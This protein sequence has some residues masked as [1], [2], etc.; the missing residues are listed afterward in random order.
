MSKPIN[1]KIKNISKS[2]FDRQSHRQKPYTLLLGAGASIS[3]GCP[4][5]WQ[6]CKQYCEEH[7]VTVVDDDYIYAFQKKLGKQ[8]RN[9]IDSYMA[10]AK[11]ISN[12]EPSMG[13]YHLATLIEKGAFETIITTNFDNL[14]EKTLAKIMPIDDIKVLIRGEVT[15]D[16][17]ADFIDKGIPK[18]K[19]I[20]LHGDLQSNIFFYQDKQTCHIS[21]RLQ[22]IL[23]S[24]IENGSIIIGSEMEDID[25][26][27]IYNGNL[28]CNYFVNPKDP[29]KQT[30]KVLNLDGNE[31][32]II[33]NITNKQT[34][35]G[36]EVETI[37][38][39]GEFDTFFTELNLEYQRNVIKQKASERKDI[40]KTILDRQEKDAGYIN[41]SRLGTMIEGFWNNVKEEYS[42]KLPDVIVFT[43]DPTAPGGMDLKRRMTDMIYESD[44]NILIET[45]KIE[46]EQ[47]RYYKRKVTSSKPKFDFGTNKKGNKDILILSAISFTGNT[48]RIAIQKYK[49]WF[50]NYSIRGGIVIIDDQLAKKIKNDSDLHNIIYYKKTDRFEVFF[51]WGVT[52]STSDSLKELKGL[53]SVYPIVIQRR[54]WGTVEVLNQQKNCSVRILTIEADQKLSFQRHL[55]RDEF[56]ISLDENIGLEICS[57]TLDD[58]PDNTDI[59]DIKG[60]KSLILEKGDYILIPKGIWHRT[61]ASKDRVRLL[62]IGYGAYD[63][64]KDIE[65][66]DDK[67]G[68]TNL[69]GSE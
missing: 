12:K 54:P 6:L 7:S 22:N 25:I 57:D 32:Q 42:E 69:D 61:K 53:D 63:Q 21:P 10:F 8:N 48:S 65:R 41:Y 37:E 66:L 1:T 44:K 5:W 55:V 3:S 50:P 20:K 43:H 38:R 45:I 13:Y 27:G 51:P 17:I 18:I 14:L 58:L 67:F 30:K 40:E 52:Q 24:N 4:S 46:G 33:T 11:S 36:K 62:E 59:N 29:S 26:L 15:D 19:I 31:E 35:N 2:I 28:A 9:R 64:N 34:C 60:I 39:I 49:E 47:T 16:Y 23:K 56:F 68:R